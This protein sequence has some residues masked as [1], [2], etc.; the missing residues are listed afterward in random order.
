[1]HAEYHCINDKNCWKYW[2]VEAHSTKKW[3]SKK[4]AGCWI[5]IEWWILL[6]ERIIRNSGWKGK[7]ISPKAECWNYPKF[8]HMTSTLVYADTSILAYRGASMKYEMLK[9]SLLLYYAVTYRGTG[10]FQPLIILSCNINGLR[11]NINSIISFSLICL[12]ILNQE[13]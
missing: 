13:N 10:K 2:I 6:T 4:E 11:I 7:D 3:W 9:R 5:V 8:R 1:M 12:L